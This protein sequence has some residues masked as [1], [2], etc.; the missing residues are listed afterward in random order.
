MTTYVKVARIK[1]TYVTLPT[2]CYNSCY[3]TGQI[4]HDII[5][6]RVKTKVKDEWYI[7]TQPHKPVTGVFW[8]YLGENWL[9]LHTFFP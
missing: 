5:Y 7:I 1:F 2:Y 3:D 4:S 9:C 8:K 6:N